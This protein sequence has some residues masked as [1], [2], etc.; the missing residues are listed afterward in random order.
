LNGKLLFFWWL[1]WLVVL[2]D[3]NRDMSPLTQ[4]LPQP[5]VI[6]NEQLAEQIPIPNRIK[7]SNR[8]KELF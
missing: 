2:P 1:S 8:T 5:I 4:T 3:K 6:Q 7:T